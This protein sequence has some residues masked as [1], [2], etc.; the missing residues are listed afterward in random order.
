MT[1]EPAFDPN[2]QLPGMPTPWAYGP[3]P[4]WREG[5]PFHMT[6]MIEAE[7]ALSERLLSR[8]AESPATTEMAAAIRAA[9]DEQAPVILTGCGTSETGAMAAVEIL[10]D[11]LAEAGQPDAMVVSEQAFE[12]SLRPPSRGV[13]IGVTHEGGTGATNAAVKAAAAAGART[14]AITASAG[15]PAGQLAD[16]VIATEELDQ[17]WCHTIGYLSPV[18]AA[19]AIAGKLTDSVIDSGAIRSLLAAGIRQAP[20]AEAIAA[21][22]APS[23]HLLAV[24]SGADRPAAREFTLK[25]EEATWLPT[26]YRDLETLLHGHLPATDSNTGLL[27]FLVERRSRDKRLARAKEALAGAAAIG[28]RAAA[29]L[30]LDVDGDVDPELTPAGRMLVPDAADRSPSAAALFATATAFQTL[31]ERL[32]RARGTNPDLIRREDE[33][34][35]RAAKVSGG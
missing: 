30:A 8:L 19:A 6:E 32:A 16:V 18:L 15:S 31:T 2:A 27:L 25:V 13:V 4:S 12:L 3:R 35:Q 34:Y 9:V 23:K 26:A 28:L 5:P 14:G 10:R 22:L 33:T 24:A 1:A 21:S 29:I 7:P 11:A 20:A 17:S